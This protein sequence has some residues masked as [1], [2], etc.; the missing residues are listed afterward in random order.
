MTFCTNCGHQISEDSKFCANCGAPVTTTVNSEQKRTTIFEGNIHKCPHCGETLKAF[1]SVCPTCGTELR[2]T[3]SSIAIISLSEKLEQADSD[4]QRI[5]IIKNFPIP[6]TKEDIFEFMV[7]ASTNFNSSYYVAHLHED[8][9]SDAWLIKIEQCYTKAKLA[10]GGDSDF[11]RIE[12]IYQK[13][14]TECEEQERW[15]KYEEKAKKD[16]QERAESEKDFKKSKLRIIVIVFAAISTLFMAVAFSDGKILA[17][18]I[19]IAMLALFVITFLMG[20]GIIKETIKNMRLIPMIIGCILIIPYFSLYSS[21]SLPSAE[22]KTIDWDQ[23]ELK[24]YVPNLEEKGIVEENTETSLH[25]EFKGLTENDHNQV[26]RDV[27]A[28][29]Y[30]NVRFT[31]S[32]YYKAYNEN[33]YYLEIWWFESSGELHFYLDA[34]IE[35]SSINWSILILSN[36]LP[37][38]NSNEGVIRTNTSERM[39]ILIDDISES[40]YN[41]FINDCK[42][43]GFTIDIR[44]D[45]GAGSFEAFNSNG[46]KIELNYN[47]CI[48]NL[49]IIVE[50]GETYNTFIWP[51][52]KLIK[53]LPKPK[54]N[55]G[56]ITSNS[57]YSFTVKVANT[58]FSD[59]QSYVNECIEK[60]YDD[61]YWW[62]DNSFS[63]ENSEGCHLS[64]EYL[65]N[66]VMEIYVYNYDY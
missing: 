28:L 57:S 49:D 9:I 6:N 64:V 11:R 34:P 36:E 18:I 17:G 54:S 38:I 22:Y 44:E 3:K 66:N 19:A 37:S 26:L 21:H 50:L 33:E 63:G 47:K 56:K 7:L 32:V 25:I 30:T 1:E 59:F 16:A 4:K 53:T 5:V 27:K 24:E 35:M 43:I 20:N 10:F 61:Y 55:I 29:G 52:T 41:A 14:K 39:D 48:Q 46:T 51:S 62:S 58:S 12:S 15:V 42:K 45:S 31:N 40:A 23:I 2:G 13:I 8:D 60:G 65:G